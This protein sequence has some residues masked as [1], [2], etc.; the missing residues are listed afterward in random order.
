MNAFDNCKLQEISFISVGNEKKQKAITSNDDYLFIDSTVEKRNDKEWA[1]LADEYKNLNSEIKWRKNR[2]E[3]VRDALIS[4]SDHS[5]SVGAGLQVQKFAR[6]GSIA[7][8]EIPELKSVDLDKY[9]GDL[10]QYWKVTEI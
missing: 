2:L 4:M 1:L 9:R 6:R 5:N 3:Q 10:V 7:Y 8:N